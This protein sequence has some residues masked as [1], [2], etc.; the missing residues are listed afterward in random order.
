MLNKF[1]NTI[2]KT[3]T[4]EG[5]QLILATKKYA[6]EDRRLSWFYTGSTFLILLSLYVLIFWID[7][8]PIQIVCSILIGLTIVRTFVIYHDYLHHAILQ[9][10]PLARVLFTIFGLYILAPPSIWKRSHDYHHKHNSKLYTSSI[11]SFP[12][13]T[14]K[15]FL[16]FSKS[17]QNAYLFIRHPLTIFLGYIFAFVYG[18][19]ILSFIRSP[20]KHWDSAIAI[21][22]HYGIGFTILMYAGWKGFILAFL[23]PSLISGGMGSYLFY[24]QHN[25]PGVTFAE[26]EGW[27]YIH[28]ALKSSS[29]MKGSRLMRWFTANIGYHHIHH[30][31]ARIP[32]Y[33]LPEVYEKFPEFQQAKT[34]SLAPADVAKCLYLKVWDPEAGKMIGLKEIYR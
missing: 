21:L 31:N 34:T 24:A 18:M 33:R 6:C 12:I 32:F 26:K 3:N 20:R 22:F 30:T 10:S 2:E 8:L 1:M 28:A 7:F 11:G 14:K 17:E 29:Y 15:K 23:V 27:T 5:K 16:S 13:V 9:K 4:L 19:S 25:F